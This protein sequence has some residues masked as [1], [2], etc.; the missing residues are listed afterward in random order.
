MANRIM[1]ALIESTGSGGQPTQ[2]PAQ[3]QAHPDQSTLQAPGDSF[4][5]RLMRGEE[6]PFDIGGTVKL[7]KISQKL[8]SNIGAASDDVAFFGPGFILRDGKTLPYVGEHFDLLE[9]AMGRKPSAN[10]LEDLRPEGIIRSSASHGGKHVNFQL[11]GEPTK[12][13]IRAMAQS[14]KNKERIV[15][16][17]PYNFGD[18]YQ[19]FDSVGS[20][21]RWFGK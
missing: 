14:S 21:M 6:M 19:V 1:Q 13:Q 12:N 11:P 3:P 20:M 2:M 16:D 10:F 7:G 17:A 9:Q 4:V 18:S 5:E 15:V 8:L